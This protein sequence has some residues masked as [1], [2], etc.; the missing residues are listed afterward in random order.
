MSSFPQFPRVA[1]RNLQGLDVSLPDAFTGRRNIVLVAFHRDQQRLVDSWL[2]WFESEAA[3]DPDLRFYEVPTIARI[4][5]PA[6][7]FIDGGMA[8]A[9]KVPAVLQRTMTVYGDVSRVTGPLGLRDSSTVA[10]VFVD[11]EGLVRWKGRGGLTDET[12]A[13]LRDALE[14]HRTL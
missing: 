8:A 2:P 3:D 14:T 11:D 9:I 10:V 12:A 7:R 5:A 6:R 13:S 1:A 4:W